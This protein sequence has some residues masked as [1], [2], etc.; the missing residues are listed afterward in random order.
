MKEVSKFDSNIKKYHLTHLDGNEEVSIGRLNLHYRKE[1][2]LSIRTV[3]GWAF[4]G[5]L[6]QNELQTVRND[7]YKDTCLWLGADPP[8]SVPLW[9]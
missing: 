1:R 2:E 6:H 5:T 8:I 3:L 7:S 9:P 4:Q